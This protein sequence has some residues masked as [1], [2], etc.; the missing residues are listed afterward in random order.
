VHLRAFTEVI[1]DTKNVHIRDIFDTKNVHICDV[2][3]DDRRAC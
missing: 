3:I 1:F 2:D